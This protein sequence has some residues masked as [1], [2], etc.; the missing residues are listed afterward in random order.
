M[1]VINSHNIM[2]VTAYFEEK[3][4]TICDWTEHNYCY[5]LLL[6]TTRK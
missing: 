1:Y 3:C 4:K 6:G 5:N 2:N